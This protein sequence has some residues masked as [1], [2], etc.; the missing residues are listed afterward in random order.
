MAAH[1]GTRCLGV[2][3]LLGA[4]SS[5]VVPM[6]GGGAFALQ[7][8]PAPPSSAEASISMLGLIERPGPVTIADL[9]RLPHQTVDVSFETI[10]GTSEQHTYTGVLLSDVVQL[11]GV[12]AEPGDR[13][14]LLRRYLTVSAHDGYRVVI[15]GGEIDPRFGN[16]PILLAWEKDGQ[17]LAGD[18]G[19]LELVVPGDTIASR[20]VWGVTEIEVLGIESAPEA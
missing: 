4:L 7:A 16:T 17:P 13:T 9:Q 10:D 11:V 2:L 14:P 5:M 3:L 6:P 8:T 20:Y 12:T 19:P 18:E 15:S 1:L